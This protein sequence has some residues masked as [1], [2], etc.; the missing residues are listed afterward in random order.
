MRPIRHVVLATYG[1]PPTPAFTAQ[2]AYSWR[3]LLGLTRKVDAIPRP[4][5]PLI[6]TARAHGRRRTW[7]AHG[8]SSPLEP[9][10]AQQAMGLQALLGQ[11]AYNIDWRVHVGYEYR[12]PHVADV[13]RGLPDDEPVWLASMYAADSA[14]TH[15]LSR[16]AAAGRTGP[17]YVLQALAPPVLGAISADHIAALTVDPRWH[18]PDVALVLAAHGTVLDPPTPIETG[19]AATDALC[20][21]IAQRAG[22]RFGLVVN[23]WLNHTRGGRWTEPPIEAA[24]AAVQQAGY[25]RAV[26]F[27]Y[28]FLGD[29]A[30]SQ[31]EGRSALAATSLTALHLPC[32]NDSASLL[33][34]LR[35]QIDACSDVCAAGPMG[36]GVPSGCGRRCQQPATSPCALCA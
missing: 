31:L 35:R 14:F 23:G 18:G 13:L 34:M 25:T 36:R 7:R 20:A 10:T 27:P 8:Y 11:T 4:L 3:I 17:T 6:A 26:Y 22:G 15:Q 2:L 16:D 24:L 32:L 33:D 19:L 5:L 12:T 29:N 28:G 9:V 21:E 1:E 30:E